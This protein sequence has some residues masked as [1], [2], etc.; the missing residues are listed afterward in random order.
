M[1]RNCREAGVWGF[2]WDCIGTRWW[3]AMR[4]LKYRDGRKPIQVEVRLSGMEKQRKP[5]GLTTGDWLS[6]LRRQAFLSNDGRCWTTRSTRRRLGS[7]L[8]TGFLTPDFRMS[9]TYRGCSR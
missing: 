9:V 3:P 1:G 5:I 8:T 6:T 7:V 2:Y 4:S